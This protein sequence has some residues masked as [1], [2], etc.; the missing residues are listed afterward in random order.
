M[1]SFAPPSSA[2]CAAA[3]SRIQSDK[4]DQFFQDLSFVFSCSDTKATSSLLPWWI[5][6][7]KGWRWRV[8]KEQQQSSNSSSLCE[9]HSPAPKPHPF[10]HRNRGYCTQ[11]ATQWILITVNCPE[12][13]QHRG[14]NTAH[15]KLHIARRAEREPTIQ[16]TQYSGHT[17]TSPF[18]QCTQERGPYNILCATKNKKQRRVASHAED[19]VVDD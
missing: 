16:A 18:C 10:A 12:L 15:S 9:C 13:A 1:R 14:Q 11:R 2:N 17:E 7:A 19:R 5:W 8:V 3:K 4:T 6:A